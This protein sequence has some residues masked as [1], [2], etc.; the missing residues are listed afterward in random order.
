MLLVIDQKTVEEAEEIKN[1]L[2]SSETWQELIRIS[3]R[4][5]IIVLLSY[6]VVGTVK[7]VIRRVFAVKY[8]GPIQRPL[9]TKLHLFHPL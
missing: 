6:A 1:F 2:L 4:V 9:G 3:I 5:L 7:L 8:K